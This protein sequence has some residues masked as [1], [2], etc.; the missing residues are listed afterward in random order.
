[1]IAQFTSSTPIWRY[2]QSRARRKTRTRGENSAA[3]RVSHFLY[4]GGVTNM[5]R[6]STMTET[7]LLKIRGIS[8]KSCN[9]VQEALNDFRADYGETS[10][11][12]PDFDS[13]ELNYILNEL[14]SRKADD[15]IRLRYTFHDLAQEENQHPQMEL[16]ERIF[17]K[18]DSVTRDEFAAIMAENDVNIEDYKL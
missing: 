15:F 16:M 5:E 4:R 12:M 18:L 14:E 7:E 11:S 13:Q 8:I 2:I 17:Y 1:M 3:G 9:F 6:L 10:W